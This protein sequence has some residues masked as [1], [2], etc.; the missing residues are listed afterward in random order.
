MDRYVGEAVDFALKHEKCMILCE[1]L[2]T[3]INI[4][5]TI[6]HKLL[7]DDF[8]DYKI[9]LVSSK[10]AVEN[11]W[12][13]QSAESTN[14]QIVRCQ[15]V[16]GS[17]KQKVKALIKQAELYLTNYETVNMP[18]LRRLAKF[19]MIIIDD[20]HRLKNSATKIFV[21][22]SSM[23]GAAKRVMGITSEACVEHL[24][25]MWAQYYL[26]DQGERLEKGYEQFCERYF[27]KIYTGRGKGYKHICKNMTKEEIAKKVQDITYYYSEKQ[28]NCPRNRIDNEKIMVRMNA[29]EY[30]KYLWF[31]DECGLQFKNNDVI[32]ADNRLTLTM[33]L[34]QMANG[35]VYTDNK[36]T[37]TIHERK[38]NALSE[39]MQK[40]SEH[41]LLICYSFEHEKDRIVE[42]FKNIKVMK[43]AH[44]I[45]EWNNGRYKRALIHPAFGDEKVNLAFGGN[46]LIWFSLTW[47]LHL[48]KRMIQ[49]M[50]S[51]ESSN[52]RCLIIHIITEGTLDETMYKGLI[53]K[54]TTQ[55]ELDR[56]VREEKLLY[57]E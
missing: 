17:R 3:R 41:N 15:I 53:E 52:H 37:V 18:L 14:S 46:I 13:C 40:Y 2:D 5:Y 39:L 50:L 35:T 43:D 36:K 54:R 8:L 28:E 32:S 24:T 20:I 1:K 34:F 29:S 48:Y 31:R 7:F 16:T 25:D 33:K 49:R 10:Y 56:I 42:Y 12:T 38:L 23:C 26:L 51:E 4:V 27:F 45:Q 55:E 19:D 30:T 6:L 9:L 22:L 57:G 44:D 47:S 21:T 11:L